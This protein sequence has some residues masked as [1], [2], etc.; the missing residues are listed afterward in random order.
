MECRCYGHRG[1]YELEPSLEHRRFATTDTTCGTS[2][3]KIDTCGREQGVP[4][5]L[6]L[7]PM[8]LSLSM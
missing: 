5:A 6:P 7:P 1:E 3:C 2:T 8:L 4:G